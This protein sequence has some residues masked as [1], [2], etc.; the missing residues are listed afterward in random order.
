MEFYS[1]GQ[2]EC[3]SDHRA[4]GNVLLPYNGPRMYIVTLLR[5]PGFGQDSLLPLKCF[6]LRGREESFYSVSR[7]AISGMTVSK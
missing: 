6:A 3:G 1:T 2:S 4:P 5:T 7:A